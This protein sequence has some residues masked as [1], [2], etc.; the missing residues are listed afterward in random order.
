MDT[1]D[2]QAILQQIDDG[3][4]MLFL[5][6]GSTRFCRRPD[7]VR[8]LTGEGLATELL[9]KLN[10]GT[11]PGLKWVGLMQ[12][13]EFFASMSAGARNAL[14]RFVQERLADLQ[15]TIGHYIATSFHWRAVV[16]T[17]YNRVAED[18]WG[19]A[20]AA[21][22]AA[23]DIIAIR[24]DADITQHYGDTKRIR[25]YKPH[26]CITIQKQQSNRMVLTSNDYFA[27]ERIRKGIYDAIRALARDCST[28]FAGYSLAD[29][30]FKNIFYTL[31]EELGQW[32]S[33]SY[34]VIPS[35]NAIYEEWLSRSM[36]ENFKTKVISE[37]FD[38]FMIRLLIARGRI[39]KQLKAKVLQ[40]WP[41]FVADIVADNKIV[42]N[43][44]Y[45]AIVKLPEV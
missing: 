24:T 25:L 35:D 31:Y 22:F 15:P 23:N 11:D 1:T 43:N 16:T 5:G 10:H 12:A 6:S 2:Y 41:N 28:V 39:H 13:S 32:A 44:L 7:G 30:T 20:H 29:Y 18:A 26:G 3:Y 9:V 36:E 8:G 19:E 37:T 4:A 34:A 38:S 33:H 17:N 21:G 14:D 27:S 45:Q 40:L 42:D